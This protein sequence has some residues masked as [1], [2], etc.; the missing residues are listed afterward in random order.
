VSEKTQNTIT[1]QT[2]PDRLLGNNIPITECRIDIKDPVTGDIIYSDSTIILGHN[3]PSTRLEAIKV[4]MIE[5]YKNH[6]KGSW[7]TIL[8]NQDLYPDPNMK[9]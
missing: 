9:T 7:Q 1:P 8:H 2:N 3:I 6:R 4:S 5:A